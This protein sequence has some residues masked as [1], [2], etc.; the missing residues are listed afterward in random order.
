MRAP[1]T[2]PPEIAADPRL[3]ELAALLEEVR[4]ALDPD[5]LERIDERAARALAAPPARSL[6]SRFRPT[7]WAPAL[8]LA[9]CALIALAVALPALRGSADRMSSS[10]GAGSSAAGGGASLAE[11]AVKPR[12]PVPT[13]SSAST[14]APDVVAPPSVP[15]AGT[16]RKVERSVA[17]T[18]GTRPRNIDAVAS[19]AGRVATTLGGY[20]AA[21]STASGSGGTL[22]LRVP[23]ARLDDAVARLSRLGHVRA[24]ERSTLDITAQAVSARGRL[25]DAVAERR[26]LLRQLSRALTPGETERIRARL[27]TVWHQIQSARAGVR[28]VNVRA[29][30]ATVSVAIAPE[31]GT[32]A[33]GGGWTPRDSL[34]NALHVLEVALGIAL[35]AFAVALPLVLLGA[36]AWLATR[37][38][39]RHRRER[40]LDAA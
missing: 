18:I 34:D 1:D 37:R 7:L 39:L 5:R 10:E 2:L 17:I 27:R 14:A 6:R 35:I 28:R 12:A 40:A 36:P 20:V 4:P 9:A 32:G 24:L 38:V 3:V 21:S 11:P 16:P 31:R 26:S 22:E 8:G 19:A 13:D 25:A 23:S 15:A 29:A 30:L 33:V